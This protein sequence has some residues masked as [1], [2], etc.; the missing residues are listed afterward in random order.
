MP[1]SVVSVSG[2]MSRKGGGKF[3]LD[4]GVNAADSTPDRERPAAKTLHQQL[5]DG[6]IPAHA[7]K[8]L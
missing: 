1:Y 3:T 2:H 4:L 7:S 8:V 6:S 5:Q